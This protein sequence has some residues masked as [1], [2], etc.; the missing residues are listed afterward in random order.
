ML[1]LSFTARVSQTVQALGGE[2]LELAVACTEVY[3]S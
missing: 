2:V 3:K 1:R